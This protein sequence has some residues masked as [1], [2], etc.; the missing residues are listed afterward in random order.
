MED[1]MLIS[2]RGAERKLI[3]DSI[4]LEQQ[5]IRSINQFEKRTLLINLTDVHLKLA[6]VT[7][8]INEITAM[9]EPQKTI[10]QKLFN[11]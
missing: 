11:R 5:I 9:P 2:L 10:W 1:T 6:Q 8:Q 3:N 7:R 4:N